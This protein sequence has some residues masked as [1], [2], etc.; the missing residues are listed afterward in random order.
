MVKLHR[1]LQPTETLF[2]ADAM[3][4]QEAVHAAEEFNKALNLSGLILTKLDGDARGGA[5][6]SI[7]AVTGIP[8]KFVGIGREVGRPGNLLP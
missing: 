3:T 7:R 8:I 6:L 2:V 4:G 5:A 1:H